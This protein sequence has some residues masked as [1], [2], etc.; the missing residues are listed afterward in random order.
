MGILE[1]FNIRTPSSTAPAKSPADMT[2]DELLKEKTALEYDARKVDREREAL[3]KQ[4]DQLKREGMQA[5]GD[6]R[7]RIAE[8]FRDMQLELGHARRDSACM[9]K[10]IR[11][12]RRLH[13][14]KARA[15]RLRRPYLDLGGIAW[16]KIGDLLR[17][18]EIEEAHMESKLDSI[19]GA[20]ESEAELT[21]TEG[22]VADILASWD[23]EELDTVE[24]DSLSTEPVKKRDRQL[25]EDFDS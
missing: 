22:A 11:V 2:P 13:S 14:I 20:S 21:Q 6:S 19:L 15:N 7:V 25:N 17:D 24:G 16:D 3:E 18:N 5:K 10:A 23:Q 1:F 9:H 12:V 4:M 8:K